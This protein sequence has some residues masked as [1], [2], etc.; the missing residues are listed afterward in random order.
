MNNLIHVSFHKVR[1][2]QPSKE[3]GNFVAVLLQIYFTICM[4]C[5]HYQNIMRF[6]KLL[7]FLPHCVYTDFDISYLSLK[8]NDKH[9][10]QCRPT[11]VCL[12]C[13]SETTRKP[14]LVKPQAS[15]NKNKIWRKTIFNMADRILTPCNVARSWHWFRQETAPC[16]VP[17]GSGIMTVNSPSDSAL[18]CDTWLWDDMPLNSPGGSTLQCDK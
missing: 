5:K 6:D 4:P 16:N 11:A 10:I 8:R 3:V 14:P 18:Q 15:K 7:Q 9:T 17:C 12:L 13:V 2:E 1:W